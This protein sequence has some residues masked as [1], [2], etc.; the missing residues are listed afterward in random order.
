MKKLFFIALLVVALVGCNTTKSKY[1]QE[2]QSILANNPE[3]FKNCKDTNLVFA[4]FKA[5]KLDTTIYRKTRFRSTNYSTDYTWEQILIDSFLVADYGYKFV[6]ISTD[7][8]LNLYGVKEYMSKCIVRKDFPDSYFSLVN[9]VMPRIKAKYNKINEDSILHELLYWKAEEIIFNKEKELLKLKNA[10]KNKVPPNVSDAY[11]YCQDRDLEKI[12]KIHL[13]GSMCDIVILG[14]CKFK[15][16]KENTIPTKEIADAVVQKMDTA[17]MF[18][19]K[20]VYDT[21]GNLIE[22]TP[23]KLKPS[24]Q[25]FNICSQACNHITVKLLNKKPLEVEL[26]VK[27]TVIRGKY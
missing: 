6:Y 14:Y 3:F 9:Y 16:G 21:L 1:T 15:F 20:V 19:I 13:D 10:G 7:S 2:A 17:G 25:L 23:R 11:I 22:A 8:I 26:L 12:T 5:V 4:A 18:P 27:P 24:N